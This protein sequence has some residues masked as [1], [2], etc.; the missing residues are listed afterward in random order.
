MLHQHPR[1]SLIE[2]YVCEML[3]LEFCD[4]ENQNDGLLETK[5]KKEISWKYH[6]LQRWKLKI[7]KGKRF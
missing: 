7:W 2:S 4:K 5:K 1:N 3:I 6:C